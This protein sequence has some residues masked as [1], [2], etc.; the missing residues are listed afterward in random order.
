MDLTHELPRVHI[1]FGYGI[2]FSVDLHV[3]IGL[4]DEELK[5]LAILHFKKYMPN[6]EQVNGIENRLEN[7]KAWVNVEREKLS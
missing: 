7:G 2:T 4:T 3:E 6:V 1:C 5:N